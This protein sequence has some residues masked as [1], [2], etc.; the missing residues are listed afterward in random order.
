MLYI[1]KGQT[2][3]I[4]I[5]AQEA[6]ESDSKEFRFV[7]KNEQSKEE[8]EITLTDS[9]EYPDRYN[10]FE[11]TEGTQLRFPLTGFYSFLVYDSLGVIVERGRARV[12]NASEANFY[13]YPLQQENT[14][15]S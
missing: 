15:Y 1:F 2:S 7:F 4:A 11:L 8:L 10:Y 14:I 6:T 3:P 12:L 9:S 5:T 13:N